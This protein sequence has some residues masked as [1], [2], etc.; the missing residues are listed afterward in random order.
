MVAQL[1]QQYYPI[2]VSTD[3]SEREKI[4]H[5]VRWWSRAHQW[6]VELGL[7]RDDLPR[8]VHENPMV[9]REGTRDL[10]AMLERAHVP[11]VVFS[12]G[13]AGTLLL[14]LP[15][16]FISPPLLLRPD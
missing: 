9:L 7:H 16:L 5:M 14:L 1:F 4:P 8:M 11:V 13:I 2:E 12:A 15:S 10:L 6:I 3:M